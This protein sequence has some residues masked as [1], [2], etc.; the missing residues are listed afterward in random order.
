VEND[1]NLAHA[2]GFGVIHPLSH[3]LLMLRPI[4][5]HSEGDR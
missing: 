4:A 3:L 2:F 1:V 5:I